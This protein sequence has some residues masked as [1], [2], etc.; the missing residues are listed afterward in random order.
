MRHWKLF[1]EKRYRC[2]D[3]TRVRLCDWADT[4]IREVLLPQLEEKDYALSVDRK[5]LTTCLLNTLYRILQPRDYV[6]PHRHGFVWT[7]E[8]YEF[9]SE[10]FPAGLWKQIREEFWLEEF[11]ERVW[12]ELEYFAFSHID[13]DK[14][15][16]NTI[17]ED[18]FKGIE[19]EEDEEG[20]E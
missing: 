5:D 10:Q 12:S 14:S 11:P 19:D 6:C 13:F 17:M 16:A 4:L 18:Q 1:L 9:F 20:A 7:P 3:G 15:R 2:S 8:Q